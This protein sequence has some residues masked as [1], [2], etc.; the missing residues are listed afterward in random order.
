MHMVKTGISEVKIKIQIFILFN[1]KYL[2]IEIK[3]IPESVRSQDSCFWSF[4]FGC[5]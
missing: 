5:N 4:H 2:N 1:F 3:L